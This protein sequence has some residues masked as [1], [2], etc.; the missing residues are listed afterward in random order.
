MLN[1]IFKETPKN[2]LIE[3]PTDGTQL[4]LIPEGEFLAGGKGNDEGKC[5]PFPVI[6]PAYYMALHPVTNAQ[7]KKFVDVTGHRPPDEV[8]FYWETPIWTG[9]N[10]PAEKAEHPVVCVSWD[11]AHAYCQWA[12]LQLPT[13]LQWEK[14]AR[15]CDGRAY[16][17]GNDWL[18]GKHC[19]WEENKG[20]ETT[21]SVWQYPTGCSP[22]G[23]YNMAGNVYEW[24]ADWYDSQAYERYKKGDLIQTATGSERLLRGGSWDHNYTYYFCCADR[25]YCYPELRV[26]FLGF[27]C[28]RPFG[29]S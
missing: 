4:V 8:D 20:S 28:I 3:N 9:K 1:K 12:G 17:W 24:C 22:Y 19:R 14:A 25:S 15:G 27:R 5:D 18:D 13:E 10:F 26:S 16:P 6:L 7:Y 23:L 11:D 29:S 2:W 21:C